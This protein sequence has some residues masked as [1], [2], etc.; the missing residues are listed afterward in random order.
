MFEIESILSLKT[1]NPKTLKV[2]CF[3]EIQNII[4]NIHVML[5]KNKKNYFYINFF[6]NFDYYNTIYNSNF[7]I[8]KKIVANKFAISKKLNN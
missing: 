7:L 2:Y 1:I 4:R 3:I 6:A 8:K 5:A